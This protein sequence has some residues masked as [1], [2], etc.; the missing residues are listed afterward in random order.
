MPDIVSE[1]KEIMSLTKRYLERKE[2]SEGNL[3]FIK[4]K[5]PAI[6]EQNFLDPE[7]ADCNKCFLAKSRRRIVWGEG[8][9]NADLLLIGEAPGEKEDLEGKPFLDKD[10]ELLTKILQAVNLQREDVYIT[11]LIKCRPEGKLKIDSEEV[12][13]C[14]KLLYLQIRQIKPKIICT[15]G[16]LATRALLEREES[17]TDLRGKIYYFRGIKVVPTFH[18]AYLLKNP[19]EKRKVWDDIQKI[20][21]LLI[22]G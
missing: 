16:N 9:K 8:N 21:D 20:R 5:E 1:F 2:E 7:M 4:P 3:F 11:N 13:N 14:L 15:L 10:G 6:S 22:S 19:K 18:P 12:I 17:I